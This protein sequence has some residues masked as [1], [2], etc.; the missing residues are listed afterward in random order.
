[1]QHEL[2]QSLNAFHQA[3]TLVAEENTKLVQEKK[4][5]DRMTNVVMDMQHVFT[6]HYALPP[7]SVIQLNVGGELI[8]TTRSTL[9]KYPNTVLGALFS[10]HYPVT[11]DKMGRVFLDRDPH[12]FKEILE[13]LRTDLIPKRAAAASMFMNNRRAFN[14]ELDYF[15]LKTAFNKRVYPV[16]LSPVKFGIFYFLFMSCVL[17]LCS[18]VH[19]VIRKCINTYTTRANNTN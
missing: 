4:K 1:V 14:A 2:D 5:V 12:I 18:F 15:G 11:R 3:V 7:E 10:G 17:I 6:E 8:T 19:S 16:N 13:W 9:M